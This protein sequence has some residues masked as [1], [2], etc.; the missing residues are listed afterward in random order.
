MNLY[1]HAKLWGVIWKYEY[2]LD[3][4]LNF[5]VGSLAAVKNEQSESISLIG[6]WERNNQKPIIQGNKTFQ[7]VKFYVSSKNMYFDVTIKPHVE[8]FFCGHNIIINII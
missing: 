6:K 1:F 2:L 8:I 3:F 4:D 7:S 5:F